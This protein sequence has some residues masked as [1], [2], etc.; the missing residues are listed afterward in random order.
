[1]VRSSSD[2][3]AV[4]LAGGASRRFGSDKT[5]AVLNG[6]TLLESV[7]DSARGL[8]DEVLVIGPWAP[9]GVRHELE[10]EPGRGPLAAV[11]FG[12]G[13]VDAARV[14]V[15]GGDHPQLAPA[16]L[17]LLMDLADDA[18]ADAVVPERAGRPEPLV[19]CY[20]RSAL[21]VAER[22]VAAGGR[23]MGSLLDELTIR[24][25]TEKQWRPLDPDGRSFR[26]V[27]RPEDLAAMTGSGPE[28]NQRERSTDGHLGD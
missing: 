12:L 13:R 28:G 18:P 25:L 5:R 27:D 15:L 11:V 7:V 17:A 6:A 26:D 9:P 22:V 24:T 8:V 2:R 1:M 16:V 19:A 10:P 23:S 14:L 4:I 3:A 20:R 21:A